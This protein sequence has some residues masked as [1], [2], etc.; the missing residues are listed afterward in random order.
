M[1][2]HAS[3]EAGVAGPQILR[4]LAGKADAARRAT[5]GCAMANVRVFV[6]GFVGQNGP[7]SNPK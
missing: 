2:A 3:A 6:A 1:T 4:R 5:R 7:R